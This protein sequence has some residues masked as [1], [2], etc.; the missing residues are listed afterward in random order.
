M[1]VH[2]GKSGP[3]PLT[4]IQ[5]NGGIIME[6]YPAVEPDRSISAVSVKF[7]RA[8]PVHLLLRIKCHGAVQNGVQHWP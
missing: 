4:I 5:D 8:P 3:E 1:A 7:P 2:T 6:R